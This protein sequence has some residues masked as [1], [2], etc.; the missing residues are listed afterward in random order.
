MSQVS[1]TNLEV[2]IQKQLYDQ[3]SYIISDLRDSK[4]VE[5]FLSELLT[6]TER[7]MLA[8]RLGIAMLLTKGYTYRDIRHVL[9]VSFPTIRSVQFW[10]EHGSKGYKK[11][12]QKILSKEDIRTFITKIDALI[13]A[14]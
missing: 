10:L 9:H 5:E 12:A 13:D 4:E 3:L 11:A 8:K 2:T 1:K 6:K 14:L 7:V